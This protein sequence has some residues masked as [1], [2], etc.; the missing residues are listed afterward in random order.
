MIVLD[1]HAL[2][3]WLAEPARLSRRARSAIDQAMASRS[4]G[5][6]SISAWEIATL[7]KKGRHELNRDA[8]DWLAQAE[9]LPLVR[10]VPVD[11]RIA[12][13]SVRLPPPLHED[14]ADRI[15]AATALVLG[16]PLVT[17]DRRLHDFPPL[18][19]VW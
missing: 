10:F 6:S 7:V 12:L 3:W 11:N 14:P 5:V 16:A 2:V 17:K 4:I 1:T 18:Q 19:T 13:R 8:G 9:A 15:I